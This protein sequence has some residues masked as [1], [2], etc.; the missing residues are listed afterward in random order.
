MQSLIGNIDA[1]VD[2]KGRAFLPVQ[3]RK[4]LDDCKNFILRKDIFCNCLVLYT[5]DAWNEI[6]SRLKMQLNNWNRQQGQIFRQFVSEA[7]RIELEENGRM[8]IP[9]RYIDALGIKSDIRF[10]GS[11]TTIEIWPAGKIEETFISPDD[12]AKELEILMKKNSD[13][14]D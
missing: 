2:S 10:V 14:A 5:E 1:R 9:R 12:F 3:L 11:D 7:D 6:V 8:L 13:N 4:Q